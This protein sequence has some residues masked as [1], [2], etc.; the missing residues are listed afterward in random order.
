VRNQLER[1][2]TAWAPIENTMFCVV[3]KDEIDLD[4][5]IDNLGEA[6]GEQAVGL[7]DSMDVI[8][9]NLDEFTEKL[10]K[11]KEDRLTEG[12]RLDNDGK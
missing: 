3:D 11:L 1:K 9:T 6:Y 7:K 5:K 12:R 2:K 8:K 10:A 4:T